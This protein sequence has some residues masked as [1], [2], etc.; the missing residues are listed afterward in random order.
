MTNNEIT[1]A[2]IIDWVKENPECDS[3]EHPKSDLLINIIQ[4]HAKEDRKSLKKIIKN[5]AKSSVIPKSFIDN[6]NQKD[7]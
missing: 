6:D 5:I 3:Y 1:I 4:N 2:K 7:V